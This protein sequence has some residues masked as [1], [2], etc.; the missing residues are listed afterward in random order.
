MY[1]LI[2]AAVLLFA[3]QTLCFKEFTHRH[4]KTKADYFLFSS[5]YFMLVVV[6]LLAVNGFGSVSPQTFMIAIPFGIVFIAAILLYM[7]AMETGSMSFSA[8]V[9][10]FGLLVPIISGQLFWQENI[11]FQQVLAL[12]VLFVS[13]YLAGGLKREP[14]LGFNIKWFVLILTATLGNGALMTLAKTHQRILPGK[15][16]GEF[17]IVAFATAALVSLLLTAYRVRI[18]RERTLRPMALPFLLVVLGAGL[19]TAF[20]NWISLSLAGKIPAYILFPLMNGGIVF[21]SS[22]LSVVVY[23]EKMTGRSVSGLVLGLFALVLICL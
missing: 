15:D 10:S 19:T 18:V 5:L 20:G 12:G 21:L 16:V 11:G 7:R 9:F 14:A 8:L 1:L 23:K 22:I 3:V 4:M 17:M 6:I 2:F 13:F